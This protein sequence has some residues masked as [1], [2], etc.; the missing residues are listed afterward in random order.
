MADTA[1]EIDLDSVIDRL[2]EGG[3]CLP[4]RTRFR[5]WFWFWFSCGGGGC[6]ALIRLPPSLCFCFC[7]SSRREL[8][9][10]PLSRAIALPWQALRI[11]SCF[12][13]NSVF[14]YDGF[15][16]MVT[17]MSQPVGVDGDAML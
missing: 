10:L 2:L 9:L 4:V 8:L 5:F 17:P 6:S 7:F 11:G 15:I 12:L 13:P 1:T 16:R 14:F 3:H